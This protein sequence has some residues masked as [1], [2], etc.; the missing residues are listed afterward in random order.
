MLT[1]GIDLINAMVDGISGVR[2]GIHLCRGNKRGDVDGQRR[3]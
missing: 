3:L 2:L 1:E